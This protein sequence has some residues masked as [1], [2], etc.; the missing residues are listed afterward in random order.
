MLGLNAWDLVF[1]GVSP[2]IIIFAALFGLLK[3]YPIRY[4]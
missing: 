3:V 1:Y 4:Y 2:G